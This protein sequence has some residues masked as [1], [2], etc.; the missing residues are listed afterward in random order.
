MLKCKEYVEIRGKLYE[1]ASSIDNNFNDFTDIEKLKF[2]FSNERMVR[3]SAKT[4]FDIL[5][6]RN[7]LL[8][9]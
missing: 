9:K 3:S 6:K 2:L 7:N 8:Y 4:C 5:N 1:K